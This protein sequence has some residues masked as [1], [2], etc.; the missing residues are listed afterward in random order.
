MSSS[1]PASK[2]WPQQNGLVFG[3]RVDQTAPS[4][5]VNPLMPY[6]ESFHNLFMDSRFKTMPV[7]VI[8]SQEP[9]QSEPL[10]LSHKPKAYREADK[11]TRI[12]TCQPELSIDRVWSMAGEANSHSYFLNV[13]H[14]PLTLTLENTAGNIFSGSGR[15]T[16]QSSSAVDILH[17]PGES[18]NPLP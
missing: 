14:P 18:F 16:S 6:G 7:R 3:L 8:S 9:A 2:D 15:S 12:I 4:N 10:D 1:G 5:Y 11:N 17:N 13:N